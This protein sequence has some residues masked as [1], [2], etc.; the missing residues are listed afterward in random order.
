MANGLNK[1]Q[2]IGNLGRDP[3]IRSFDNDRKKVTFSLATSRTYTSRDG[4]ATTKTEWHNVV[5]WSPLAGIAEKYLSKGRQVYIEG[6]LTTRS[7]KGS[8]GTKKYITEIV[9]RNML[10]LNGRNEAMENS[11]ANAGEADQ[12]NASAEDELPF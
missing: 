6:E 1:V 5:L 2:L 3:E 4:A 8:D 9:G 12:V 10:L 7:Y 11:S